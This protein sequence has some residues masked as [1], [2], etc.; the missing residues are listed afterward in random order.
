MDLT[1]T[2]P[3]IISAGI[4]GWYG[5]GVDRL[6]RSLIFNGF[7]GEMIMWKNDYPPNSPSHA[8]NPYAFKVYAFREAIKRGHTH[9]MWLDASFWAIKNPI[10]LFD[11]IVDKGIFAFKSG[12]NCA[13]TCTDKLLDA[14]T[15]SRDEAEQLPEIATGI[16]GLNMDNPD[17][18]AVW[19]W[20][21]NMCDE[22]F[23]KNSR[24]HNPEESRDPRFL[25]GRQDQ[26]CFS[27]AVHKNNIK[28]DYQDY[29]AYYQTGHNPD[30]CI[31]FIG[32]L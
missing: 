12:Y 26:S 4:G 5:A 6:E 11:I 27:M 23:F 29:V 3:C 10:E 19:D 20:W 30:K 21:S 1:Q 25:H 8:D 13:Q 14:M 9:I 24:T 31:F 16:V 22:G 15:M 7:P 2:K 32:G 17:G 18:K 28:F